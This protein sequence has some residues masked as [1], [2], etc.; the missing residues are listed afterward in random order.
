M[1]APSHDRNLRALSKTISTSLLFGHVRAAGP[2]ASVHQYNCHPF[3]KGRY[4]FMHNGDISRFSKIRRGLL[5][6]LR[7]ELFESI[8]GT[9]DS[10]LLFHLIL[11][12]LPDSHT[13]QD[14]AVLQA[15]VM[16][17][18]RYVIKANQGSPNS[19]NVA[20]TDGETVIATRYR[21]SEHEEPPSLYF[22]L[23]PMPG[24][25]T[26]DLDRLGGF[27]SMETNASAMD[28]TGAPRRDLKSLRHP[29]VGGG[30]GGG[31][32]SGCKEHVHNK[33]VATQAL[34]VSSEPLSTH[35]LDRWQLCPPNSMIIAAPTRPMAGRCTRAALVA[36]LKEQATGGGRRHNLSP[37]SAPVLE[38]EIKC[39]KDLCRDALGEC[40]EGVLEDWL[41]ESKQ[42]GIELQQ[43]R[44]QDMPAAPPPQPASPSSAAART[45]PPHHPHHFRGNSENLKMSMADMAASLP[46]GAL[47][48]ASSVGG[49]LPEPYTAATN[50]TPVRAVQ[51]EENASSAA[52]QSPS[53]SPSHSRAG[54]GAGAGPGLGPR[55]MMS[56]N[57]IMGFSIDPRGATLGGGVGAG[58]GGGSVAGRDNDDYN[59]GIDGSA[60]SGAGG[61]GG[62]EVLP[63]SS[64]PGT[65]P[66]IGFTVSDTY[67][68]VSASANGN[69]NG[70][71]NGN[72]NGKGSGSGDGDGDCDGVTPIGGLTALRV[73]GTAGT[74]SEAEGAVA[75]EIAVGGEGGRGGEEDELSP[76]RRLARE[77]TDVLLSSS[78]KSIPVEVFKRTKSIGSELAA[79]SWSGH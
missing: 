9:T 58:E 56:G 20:L 67:G 31:G 30:G 70:I 23:G 64:L 25:K 48:S 69:G 3:S 38:I 59:E 61:G 34:L 10:E 17:A 18:L 15:A 11:N 28:N 78:A 49:R 1:A 26:W 22:H 73:R 68:N 50:G 51:F 21:N 39:M 72:G 12:E 77:E 7:D 54:S 29:A 65:N 79:G 55:G 13:P 47:R 37:S 45:P 6:K 36:K 19:L 75:G 5:G 44:R 32:W 42:R 40:G 2:G 35:G 24:E 16:Q 53:P 8:S 66:V 71:G 43:K 33:F 57:P 63:G 76:A 41:K 60:A 14:P 52:P 62:G 74:A 4:M 46:T 27:D